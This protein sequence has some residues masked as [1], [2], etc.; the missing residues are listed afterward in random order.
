MF[1]SIRTLLNV[2]HPDEEVRQRG[3]N[4]IIIAL[5]LLGINLVVVIS[6]LFNP[7]QFTRLFAT[8]VGSV[9]LYIF[10]IFITFRGFVELAGWLIVILSLVGTIT[11]TLANP[12]RL[13]AIF[14][15]VPLVL[16]V[17]ILSLRSL[18]LT[19]LLTACCLV[20]I[21]FFLEPTPLNL[22]TRDFINFCGRALWLSQCHQFCAE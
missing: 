16:A 3:R 14:L 5:D 10:V 15:S 19:F 18:I 12:D 20:G 22:T 9:I 13:V 2:R 7:S 21:A 4:I 17:T 8:S 11:V 6:L 1:N